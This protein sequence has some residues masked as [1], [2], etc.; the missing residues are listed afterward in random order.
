L[1][2]QSGQYLLEAN[3]LDKLTDYQIFLQVLELYKPFFYRGRAKRYPL[4]SK[5][6]LQLDQ[7]EEL[8]SRCSGENSKVILISVSRTRL[9]SIAKRED[10]EHNEKKI[11]LTEELIE[12]VGDRLI[13]LS[14][15]SF[16]S[17]YSSANIIGEEY[18]REPPSSYRT[19]PLSFLFDD[20]YARDLSALFISG[21]SPEIETAIHLAGSFCSSFTLLL[22]HSFIESIPKNIEDSD[23]WS[24]KESNTESW[25]NWVLGKEKE[26]LKE[27]R[28]K[29]KYLIPWVKLI[30]DCIPVGRIP[31]TGE[32]IVLSQ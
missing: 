19:G 3:Q 8:F 15:E 25:V 12:I 6:E 22:E 16:W 31:A 21:D 1:K 24:N 7:I 26:E 4:I 14:L 28:S 17:D 27:Q 18:F 5:D 23:F 13:S 20:L 32:W 9:G 11:A 2:N 29:I 30:I 10:L